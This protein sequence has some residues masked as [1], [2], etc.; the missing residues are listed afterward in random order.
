MLAKCK[1]AHK[2]KGS[3]LEDYDKVKTDGTTNRRKN[4]KRPNLS[5]ASLHLAI[6]FSL[7]FKI[8]V[9]NIIFHLFV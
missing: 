6:F 8:T 9:H 3:R 2:I 4:K 5:R 1:N 7:N